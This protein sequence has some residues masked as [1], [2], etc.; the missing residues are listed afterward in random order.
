[1]TNDIF[2]LNGNHFKFIKEI[3]DILSCEE[4]EYKDFKSSINKVNNNI[5]INNNNYFIDLLNLNNEDSSNSINRAIK[6]T[7]NNLTVIKLYEK[8][9]S[10][11]AKFYLKVNNNF[12]SFSFSFFILIFILI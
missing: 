4:I 3:Y 2:E 12:F 8:I 6:K 10:N 11:L 1:M 9:N 5:N 7:G